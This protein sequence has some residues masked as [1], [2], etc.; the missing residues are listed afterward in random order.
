MTAHPEEMPE[1]PTTV[2]SRILSKPWR[3]PWCPETVP[4]GEAIWPV[5]LGN[6]E[7]LACA[8]CSWRSENGYPLRRTGG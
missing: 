7:T 8:D 1:R 2:P 4:A 3:C 6:V 5:S